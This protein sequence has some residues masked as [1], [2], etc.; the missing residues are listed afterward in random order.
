MVDFKLKLKL[1]VKDKR[2]PVPKPFCC[3]HYI[4]VNPPRCCSGI[5][6]MV[7]EHSGEVRVVLVTSKRR[8][9]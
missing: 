9:D 1:E 3:S 4:R 5:Q 2:Q 6:F 7:N 8:C